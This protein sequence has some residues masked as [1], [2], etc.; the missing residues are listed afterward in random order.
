M[1]ISSN[2]FANN[3]SLPEQYAFCKFD[4]EQHCTFSGNQNP[5]LQWSGAPAETKSFAL[6]CYDP[7]V[8][9]VG[10]DVN[11][12]GKQVSKDLPRVDFFHWLV[13]NIPATTT[14]VT[15]GTL[16][17]GVTAKG[18][19]PGKDAL[20][21]CGINDYTNWFAGDPDM[22]GNYGGYDGPCP[23]WNDEIIHHYHFVIYA[24][25]VEHIDI[26]EA[27]NGHELREA[28]KDHVIDQAALIGT[29]TLNPDLR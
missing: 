17:D 11:Q 6:I 21:V 18:K 13:A 4:A 19:T 10:D 28:I 15:A 26:K 16:S 25:N 3:N 8:P 29:F 14:S 24:L 2:A 1:K 22:G 27:F 5:D 20:G 7:D 12:E 9:S 23:P